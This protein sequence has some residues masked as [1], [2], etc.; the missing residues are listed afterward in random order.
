MFSPQTNPTSFSG[1]R[2][3]IKCFQAPHNNIHVFFGHIT[4]C[5]NSGPLWKIETYVFFYFQNYNIVFFG[6]VIYHRK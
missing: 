5:Y 6:Q 4:F 2:T 1:I 3:R